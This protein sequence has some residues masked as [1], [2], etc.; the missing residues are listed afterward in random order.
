MHPHLY[1]IYTHTHHRGVGEERGEDELE[2][3][4]KEEEEENTTRKL[5]N[6]E[7]TGMNCLIFFCLLQKKKT[8]ER[9]KKKTNREAATE[10]HQTPTSPLLMNRT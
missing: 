3:V 9:K 6:V 7:D 10:S 4:E 2:E 5:G 1:Q 8:E